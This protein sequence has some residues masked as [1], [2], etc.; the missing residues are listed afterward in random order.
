MPKKVK[1][2]KL[3]T[4]PMTDSSGM[5]MKPSKVYQMTSLNVEKELKENKVVKES[6]VF[7]IPKNKSR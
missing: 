3:K 7:E 4:V 2:K 6:D 5:D 1:S